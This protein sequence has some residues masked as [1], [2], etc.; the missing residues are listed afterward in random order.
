MI[1]RAIA[2][3]VLLLVAT[4]ASAQIF[5]VPNLTFK[6]A[7]IATQTTTVVI[8]PESGK[9]PRIVFLLVCVDNG[10]AA[11]TVTVQDG[12]GTNLF[13]TGVVFAMNTNTCLTLPYRGFPYGNAAASGQGIS[14][15]TGTGN[16]PYEVLIEVV[17]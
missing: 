17:Q 3:V 14:V 12:A 4:P 6:S 5:G 15:V 13:G 10:G 11:G 1:R 7:H 9:S 8:T 2:L 16:G